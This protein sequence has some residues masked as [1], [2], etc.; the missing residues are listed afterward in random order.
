VVY[1][2]LDNKTSHL[3]GKEMLKRM[4]F[5]LK[6][7][8]CGTEVVMRTGKMVEGAAITIS[9]EVEV[10]YDAD[11]FVECKCGNTIVKESR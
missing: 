4:S 8:E 10:L 7:N 1:C 3:L 2:L 9:G 11:V 5:T 6:C